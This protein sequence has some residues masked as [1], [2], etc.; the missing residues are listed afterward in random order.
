MDS[1]FSSTFTSKS[2]RGQYQ[3]PEER[4]EA[5][6]ILLTTETIKQSDFFELN[7]IQ[8]SNECMKKVEDRHQ[9]LFPIT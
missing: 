1:A 3:P 4:Q 8:N 5:H 9:N 6:K 7:V 2:P